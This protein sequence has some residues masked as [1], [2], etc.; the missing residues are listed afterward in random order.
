MLNK[1]EAWKSAEMQAWTIW[2]EGPDMQGYAHLGRADIVIPLSVPL[3]VMATVES[4][5]AYVVK[6]CMRG[7]RCSE[8]RAYSKHRPA[9]P[10][11]LFPPHQQALAMS[12]DVFFLDL[13]ACQA[14]PARPVQ[15]VWGAHQHW[16]KPVWALSHDAARQDM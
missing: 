7:D 6:D 10:A 9:K 14:L 11:C 16:L 5:H 1:A 3:R 13:H 15:P 12:M 2:K 8:T 4:P